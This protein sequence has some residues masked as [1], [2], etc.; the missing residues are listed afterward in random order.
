SHRP[1]RP[2][3]DSWRR[4]P[5][6]TRCQDRKGVDAP[7]WPQTLSSQ[8]SPTSPTHQPPSSLLSSLLLRLLVSLTNS[9]ITRPLLQLR[10]RLGLG[11]TYPL[12][13]LY[14]L[15]LM[16]RMLGRTQLALGV[17]ALLLLW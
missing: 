12:L 9:T 6:N 13:T 11:T 7:L 2:P 8:K 15:M 1:G 5:P 16:L 10:S 17:P 4:A 3:R 14:L